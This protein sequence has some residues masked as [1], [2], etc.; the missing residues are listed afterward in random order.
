MVVYLEPE[1]P[2][3]CEFDQMPCCYFID[4]EGEYL[5]G[6]PIWPEMTGPRGV[7][8]G[9]HFGHSRPAADPDNETELSAEEVR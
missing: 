8:V 5:Y 7:K 3:K 9:G 2:K 6:F 1:E 4:T